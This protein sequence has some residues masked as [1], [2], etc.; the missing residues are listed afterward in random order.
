M[1]ITPSP[2]I[3]QMLGQIEFAEWQCLSEL[4]D[5]S[6]DAL[7]K[8]S[9]SGI[10]LKQEYYCI[11]VVLPDQQ[12][13]ANAVVEVI[14]RA[15]GMSS[16]RLQQAVRAGWSGNDQ[17]NRLGLF[18][19]GF[20]IATARLGTVT[21]VLTTSKGVSEWIGVKIDLQSIGSD[22]EAEDI[23]TPKED[24][25]IHGT[26]VKI[27]SLDVDRS[28]SLARRHD[29]IRHKLGHIYSWILTHTNIKIRVNGRLI[30]PI[31]LCAWSE[32]RSVSRG[33]GQKMETIP[34]VIKIDEKL[35]DAQAC[36]DCGNWQKT[37]NIACNTCGG[38][39]LETRQR[40][41][42]GWVGIQRYLHAS[43]YGIDFLRNG[44]K[45]VTYDKDVF[46]WLDPDGPSDS[47][48]KE[49]P[50]EVPA[51]KGRII[52]EIHLDHVPVHYM[53]DRFD[54]ADRSW[55]SA[56][57]FLRGSGPLKPQLAKQHG[58]P[59]NDSPIGK[60]FRG[61]RRNDPG[62]KYLAPGDGTSAINQ[63][64]H[65]W[66]LKFTRGDTDYQEDTKWW[67]AV[68]YHEE[69]K[70]AKNTPSTPP[71]GETPDEDI[72]LSVL[73]GAKNK[74]NPNGKGKDSGGNTSNEQLSLHEK[75]NRLID[76]SGP[77]PILSRDI[78]SRSLGEKINVKAFE[79][80]E[81]PLIDGNNDA[82][83]AI[84]LSPA[85][86]GLINLFVDTSHESFTEHGID[87]I[88]MAL[89]QVAY[90]MLVRSGSSDYSISQVIGELRKE[91]FPDEKADF[92]TVQNR[93]RN[94]AGEIKARL[95]IYLEEDPS[96]AWSLLSS[97]E[98]TQMESS[99][100]LSGQ[101]NKTIDSSD[102]T[103]I[104]KVPSLFL[105]KLFDEW[106]ELFLDGK[107]FQSPYSNLQDRPVK[108]ISKSRISSLLMDLTT[109]AT[110]EHPPASL[111]QLKR[112]RLAIE[113]LQ[114]ELSEQ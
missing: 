23:Q 11:E 72:V 24:N 30:K 99:A 61:F 40:R 42:H 10:E 109:I 103:F 29:Y 82:Q 112:A 94:L 55:K 25:E 114:S 50:T 49:Y 54:T 70:S 100:V 69:Q 108:Q 97:E 74:S 6:I 53:K 105:L 15:P 8:A 65:D 62:Y 92:L 47:P 87:V 104:D 77:L 14:D 33:T 68:V 22:F 19:M 67:E 71:T 85:E 2:R 93:A 86:G 75:I 12:N 107:V 51:D 80:K 45:I 16:E 78:Y 106:P 59:E 37:E 89:A 39:R 95:V 17:F 111:N 110:E 41:I 38:S 28:N 21:E 63:Q 56:I 48:E 91:N 90:F 1:H 3:L 73:K 64:A 84:W 18:G 46:F 58:Y 4:I 35:G 52:G 44:R 96:R 102:P 7:M 43:E 34:A 5:N 101:H 32:N 113:I 83:T 27:S 88:D 79:I 66:G 20:N 60:L 76:N 31:K 26:V 98:I 9:E 36:H 81:S 57:T 13:D